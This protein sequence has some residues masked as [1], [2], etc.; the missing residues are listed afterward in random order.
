MTSQRSPQVSS[1]TIALAFVC[2][3]ALVTLFAGLGRSEHAREATLVGLLETAWPFLAGL[4]VMWLATLAYRRPLEIVR[5]GIPV[6]IGTVAIGMGLRLLTGSGAAL[7][8]VLVATITLAVFLLGWRAIAV[9]A[10]RLRR[11]T[12]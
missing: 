2:D 11:R 5:T 4:A 9:L 10:A 8:F 12:R 6:W 1:L 3:A 7:P